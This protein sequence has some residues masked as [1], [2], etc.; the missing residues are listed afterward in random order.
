MS[1]HL[2]LFLLD[3]YM[4]FMQDYVKSAYWEAGT[5]QVYQPWRRP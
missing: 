5:W 2:N 4:L 1:F 3:A